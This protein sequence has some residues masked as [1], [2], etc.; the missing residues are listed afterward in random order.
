ML[1]GARCP[2][3]LSLTCSRIHVPSNFD[4]PANRLPVLR[5]ILSGEEIRT[6]SKDC[7]GDPTRYVMK[8]GLT[9][10]TT[11]GCL[12]G[13]EFHV[14]RYFTLGR[15]NSV[16]AAVYSFYNDS[17]PFSEGGDS[18]SAIVDAFSKFTVLLTGGMGS[19]YFSDIT[20]GTP[21]CWLWGIIKAEFPGAKLYFGDDD[22]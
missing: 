19:A 3:G 17:S 1:S 13:F 4:Y 16:E 22:N 2:P 12:N 10:S 5:I 14:C 20:F 6:P 8:R 11:V 21:M 15:R 7:K 18:G 9:T